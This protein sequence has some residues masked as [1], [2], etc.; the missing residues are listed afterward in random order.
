MLATGCNHTPE[1][2]RQ[3][4]NGLNRMSRLTQCQLHEPSANGLWLIYVT[5]T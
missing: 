5:R 3:T 1:L 4:I 2:G